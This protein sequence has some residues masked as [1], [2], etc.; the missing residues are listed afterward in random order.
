MM[1]G[2]TDSE[3]RKEEEKHTGT[4]QRANQTVVCYV[5]H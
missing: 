2:A 4:N 3:E 1:E 5:A